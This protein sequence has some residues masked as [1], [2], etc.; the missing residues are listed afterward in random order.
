MKRTVLIGILVSALALSGCAPSPAELTAPMEQ[1]AA[2]TQTVSSSPTSTETATPIPTLASQFA[3]TFQDDFSDPASGWK[4]WNDEI[5]VAGYEDGKFK[6]QTF[7][8][9]WSDWEVIPGSYQD[10]RVSVDLTAWN[11]SRDSYAGLICRFQDRDNYI[12]ATITPFGGYA[13]SR[14]KAGDWEQISADAFDVNLVPRLGVMHLLFECLGEELNL[15]ANGVLIG[16][17][18]V[19]EIGEGQAGM[20]AGAYTDPG[21]D[22]Y[23]DNFN[24]YTFQ[25]PAVETESVSAGTANLVVHAYMD[26]SNEPVVGLSIYGFGST[27]AVT[28]ADGNLSLVHLEPGSYPVSATWFFGEVSPAYCKQPYLPEGEWET[29]P[30]MASPPEGPLIVSEPQYIYGFALVGEVTIQANATAT[31]DLAFTCK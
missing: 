6:I 13:M 9:G 12:V 25:A 15:Y 10:V 17:G 18:K 23:F 28:G 16:S 14:Q 29:T 11:G 26:G 7:Q 20:Y 24:L 1:A 8:T 22:V 30:G 27:A 2:E 21:I 5:V 19:A 3:L 31:L 4:G